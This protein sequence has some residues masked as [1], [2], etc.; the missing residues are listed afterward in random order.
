MKRTQVQV[1]LSG[2]L[3]NLS[4]ARLES[5]DCSRLEDILLRFSSTDNTLMRHYHIYLF[6]GILLACSNKCEN[7]LGK[8][9]SIELS[10]GINPRSRKEGAILDLELETG[11]FKFAYESATAIEIN[12]RGKTDG[13]V[14][15]Y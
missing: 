11:F 7:H 1:D 13:A 2:A 9:R 3:S 8:I 15:G 12:F 14:T 5:L 4:G 10:R 6:D